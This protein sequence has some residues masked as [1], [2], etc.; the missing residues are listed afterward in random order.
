MDFITFW[1]ASSI[2]LTGAF[3]ILGLLKDF[4]AKDTG[5]ITRWGKVSLIGIVLSVIMGLIAQQKESS[6]QQAASEATA[7]ETL[8]LAQKTDRTLQDL[9]RLLSAIEEPTVIAIFQVDCKEP[10]YEQV[11]STM[12]YPT[13]KASKTTWQKWPLSYKTPDDPTPTPGK[14][15]FNLSLSIYRELWYASRHGLDGHNF[16][17]LKFGVQTNNYEANGGLELS[18]SK[19]PQLRITNKTPYLMNYSSKIAGFPDL[20]GSHVIVEGGG[21]DGLIGLTPLYLEIHNKKG[22]LV[23]TMYFEKIQL[24]QRIAFRAFFPKEPYPQPGKMKP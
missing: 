4:K 16:P 18:G 22:Q 12:K 20:Y 3:G 21:S 14:V 7:N 24:P 11:C 10:R 23:Q 17:D 1:K 6:K 5:R 19:P 2:I 8:A 9:Q 13:F 15:R